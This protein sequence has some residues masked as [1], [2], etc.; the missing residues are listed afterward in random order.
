MSED[1]NE[2]VNTL[3]PSDSTLNG[4]FDKNRV[5]ITEARSFIKCTFGLNLEVIPDVCLDMIQMRRHLM[6]QL[7]EKN[8]LVASLK[9]KCQQCIKSY[10]MDM[11]NVEPKPQ[12]TTSKKI[13]KASKDDL[14]LS[15]PEA[16]KK[17]KSVLSS[18]SSATFEL[19]KEKSTVNHITDDGEIGHDS[20]DE[21]KIIEESSNTESVSCQGVTEVPGSLQLPSVSIRCLPVTDPTSLSSTGVESS[22]STLSKRLRSSATTPG[23]VQGSETSVVIKRDLSH[24][25]LASSHHTTSIAGNKA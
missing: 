1:G 14:F 24:I 21:K 4:N 20:K 2:S 3:E 8:K 10:Q 18:T 11:A 16:K 23:D 25:S 7:E 19:K 17:K 9:S 22:P 5:T 13:I 12:S 15:T 6:H